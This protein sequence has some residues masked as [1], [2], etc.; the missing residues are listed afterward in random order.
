MLACAVDEHCAMLK[1]L[2]PP[3]LAWITVV[4]AAMAGWYAYQASPEGI[5]IYTP[6][7][8]CL[9]QR[10]HPFGLGNV[11]FLAVAALLCMAS[12]ALG[13]AEIILSRKEGAR[14]RIVGLSAKALASLL[15]FGVAAVIEPALE[16]AMPLKADPACKVSRATR[17]VEALSR[18]PPPIQKSP[19]SK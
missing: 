16:R 14:P 13:V 8:W 12:W 17:D 4:L 19:A 11:A 18:A 10:T 6:R 7:D 1:M 2:R 5:Y 3:L 9:G 15:L